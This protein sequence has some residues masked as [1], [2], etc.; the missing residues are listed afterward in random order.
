MAMPTRRTCARHPDRGRA[1][2]AL[3]LG[4]VA[5]SGL[6]AMFGSIQALVAA[7]VVARIVGPTKTVASPIRLSETPVRYDRAPPALG[8]DTDEVLKA[9]G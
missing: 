9:L 7:F 3:K 1:L 6:D 2:V 8:A 4:N 5:W